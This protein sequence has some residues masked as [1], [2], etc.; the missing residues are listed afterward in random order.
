ML[1]AHLAPAK[2]SA[3]QPADQAASK[4]AGLQVIAEAV[5]LCPVD[6]IH[7]VRRDQLA[8]LEWVMKDCHRED[9][10]ILARR[11]ASAHSAHWAA[12]SADTSC[13]SQ[14]AEAMSC[15]NPQP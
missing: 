9:A 8:L 1:H 12:A 14:P 10:A 13:A 4:L 15:L 6:C 3:A 11:S 5:D 7:F 2:Q